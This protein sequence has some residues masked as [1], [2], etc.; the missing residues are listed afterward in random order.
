MKHKAVIFIFLSA[1]I[2]VWG[3]WFAGH[4]DVLVAPGQLPKP[5]SDDLS[6]RIADEPQT[7]VILDGIKQHADW[8]SQDFQG[9]KQLFNL[10]RES[11]HNGRPIKQVPPLHF[12][13]TADCAWVA[14][15][16]FEASQKPIRWITRRSSPEALFNRIVEKL[17]THSSF[18]NFH[19]DDPARCRILLEVINSEQPVRLVDLQMSRFD[20]NRF[21]PGITGLKIV[22]EGQPWFYMPTDAAVKSHLTLN[23]VL[24]DVGKKVGLGKKTNRISERIKMLIDL[25]V[26][27]YLTTS[28]AVVS[29]GEDILPLYRGYPAPV[30]YDPHRI[31]TMLLQTGRW[32]LEN[33]RPD[34][35]F[36]YYYDGVTDSVIDHQH[37]NRTLENNYYN[38]LRHCGGT[39]TLLRLYE[40]TRQAEYLDAARKTLDYLVEQ[41]RPQ[42]WQGHKACYVFYNEKAKLGGSGIALAALIRYDQ[43]ANDGR[44]HEVA[45]GLA[46]HLL[47]RIT[48]DGEMLGYYIHPR[49]HDGLPLL[50]PTAKEKKELFSFYY[51]GEALMGLALYFKHMPLEASRRRQVRTLSR[52]AMDYLIYDRPAKYAD[53]F[54]PLPSDG[55]LMQAIEEWA[56]VEGFCTSDDID[57]VFNDAKQMISHMYNEDNSL[58]YDY[59][60]TFFYNYGDHG[61]IDGARA[62]GLVAACY[63]AKKMK[64][65]KLA[66]FF[67]DNCKTVAESL[68]YS[69]NSEE[70]TYMHKYPEKSIGTFRFKFTR[71]WVRV[72]TSQHSGCFFFRFLQALIYSEPGIQWDGSNR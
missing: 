30:Q 15:T 28:I 35:R 33:L 36:L 49:Y 66:E 50:S 72:D 24:N 41:L 25:P 56:D 54:E 67:L 29:F 63:L 40:R 47:S 70:S 26:Q 48:D 68:M 69:Y 62:E 71:H 60:G 18:D 39:I 52:K 2:L 34:G 61:Y 6:A 9:E 7:H 21:E 10:L 22:H 16:L 46:N 51:P 37:P 13:L 57:F 38:I 19:V 12:D 3:I 31:D 14:V 65:E 43:I 4:R 42:D 8:F 45:H 55:W 59:P 58:Y 53:L 64:N 23:H 11:L 5:A 17:R 32:L 20:Q 44:Y 1:L 27:A